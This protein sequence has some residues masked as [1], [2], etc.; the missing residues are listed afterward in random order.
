VAE[1]GFNT[2]VATV[3]K[4]NLDAAAISGL[5]VVAHLPA[6]NRTLIELDNH[7]ALW[8]WYLIDEP[9]MHLVSP[10]TVIRKNANLKRFARKPT[11]VVLMSGAAA[12]RY[13]GTADQLA[14]D[15]YP[16]PWAP[17]GTMAR[18]M[19][20]ARLALNGKPFYAILQAFDWKAFPRLLRTDAA[21]RPPSREELRCMAYLALMQG[22][23]GV[24]FYTYDVANWKLTDHPDLWRDSS[25]LAQ[26]IG[27]TAAIFE[28][29]VNWWRV[30]SET[31]GS[32][33]EMYNEI[34]EARVSLA[35]FKVGKGAEGV[36]R[37][38]YLVAA[39]TTGEPADFSFEL[40]FSNV[41]HFGTDRVS[42]PFVVEG[43]TVRKAYAPF[44]VAIFGPILGEFIE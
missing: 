7:P 39:N 37:G 16:V 31:H 33:A 44:E 17:I 35:L 43:H 10:K 13:R 26:E 2:V 42:E 5:K 22:A 18:E 6:D 19:R 12:E 25:T 8:M 29:R 4:E 21:L 1:A 24:F 32:P 34:M 20:L 28:E 30:D 36:S 40:P 27:D 3:S 15:W 41:S 23:S 38:Y 11:L 9:D 14:V